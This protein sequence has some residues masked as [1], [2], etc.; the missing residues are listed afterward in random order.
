LKKGE[1]G[2]E[3]MK[4]TYQPSTIKRKRTSWILGEDGHARWQEGAQEKENERQKR[5]VV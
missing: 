2:K 3:L 5:L 4:R 1:R